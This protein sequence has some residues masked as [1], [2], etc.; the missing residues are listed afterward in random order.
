MRI[1]YLAFAG[2]LAAVA[3]LAAQA[4]TSPRDNVVLATP[5]LLAYYNFTSTT[6]LKN[7]HTL[8][9]NNGA[10]LGSVGGVPSL[11]LNNGK[12]GTAYAS[13]GGTKPLV[14]G[15]SNSGSVLATID[16]ASLPSVAGRVFSI[17]GSSAFGDDLDLQ[18]DRDNIIRFFTDGGSYVGN[19]QLTAAD[20]NKSIEIAATFTASTIRNLYINGALVASNVPGGH[21]DSNN[22][23]YVGQSNVFGGRYFDGSITD[24]GFFNTQLTAAQVASIYASSPTGGGGGGPVPEPAA[25]ALLGLGA[26]GLVIARRRSR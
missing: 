24:V 18:I 5:G 6:D 11:V 14:G 22:P 4:G 16:L 21:S 8:T 1:T 23:F 12:S 17:A 10:T 3:P 7:G 19:A 26:A 20:L 9:L 15:I 2:L 13:S 25:L